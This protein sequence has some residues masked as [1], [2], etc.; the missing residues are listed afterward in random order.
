MSDSAAQGGDI[1]PL[2]ETRKFEPSNF[3]VV[4]T[5]GTGSF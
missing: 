2:P 1:E 3:K 5:L 4:R